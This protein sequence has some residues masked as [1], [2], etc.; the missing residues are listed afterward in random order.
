MNIIKLNLKVRYI[1]ALLVDPV[2]YILKTYYS[3]DFVP[4]LYHTKYH[5]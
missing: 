4:F 5:E 2:K 3:Y 1:L